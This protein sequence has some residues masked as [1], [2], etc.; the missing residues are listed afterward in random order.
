MLERGLLARSP[1]PG[2]RTFMRYVLKA[3]RLFDERA[4]RRQVRRHGDA[5]SNLGPKR[6]AQP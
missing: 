2:R 6:G 3:A 1:H 5:L 4:L